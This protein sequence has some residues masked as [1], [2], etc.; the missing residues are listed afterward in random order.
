MPTMDED[1]FEEAFTN[2]MDLARI[3]ET[4]IIELTDS[5]FI[6]PC[7][8]CGF[9][10]PAPF[11]NRATGELLCRPCRYTHDEEGNHLDG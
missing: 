7:D 8:C 6:G 3:V 2:A 10:V 1:E 4:F 9:P 11:V 5:Q